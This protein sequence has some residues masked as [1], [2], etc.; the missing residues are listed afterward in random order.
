MDYIYAKRKRLITSR[1]SIRVLLFLLAFSCIGGSGNAQ[2]TNNYTNW[3]FG[4]G[5]GVTF[6]SGTV[7]ALTTGK[8]HS[9]EGCA[10]ISDANGQLL[11]YTDGQTI[12][13]RNHDVMPG[14]TGLGGSNS[15][16]QSALIVPY[17]NSTAQFYVFSVAA[18]ADQTGVQY[19]IV[20]MTLDDGR[21]GLEM[22]NKPV[23]APA[24][25][26]ITAI[27]HCNNL[28]HWIITHERGNNVFRV[29]LLNDNGLIPTATM[30]RVGSTHSSGKGYMKPSHDGRKL[31]VAVSGGEQGGFLE[32]F[33]FD[34]KTGAISKPVKLEI[35]ESR[36]AY[37]VEF[38]PDNKLL[39]LSTTSS[40][41]IYQFTVDGLAIQTA[42]SVK[43]QQGTSLGVGALQL[44]P[45]GK[46]YGA[47]PG[48]GYLLAI[49]QPNQVGAGCGLVSK[50]IY[51]GGRIAEAG[52]PF[53]LDEIPLLPPGLTI[54]LTKQAG[55][56]KYVLDSQPVNL[57]PAYLIY[58]W[59]VNGV[60][61]AGGNG[62][63]LQPAKSGTYTLKV[64]ETKCR[65]IQQFSNEMP[66][67]L[68]EVNPTVTATPDSCGTFRLA[69]HAN[70]GNIVWRGPGINPANSHLDSMIIAGVNGNRTYQVRV[71]DP[72]DSTCS[73]QKEV[74]FAFTVPPAFQ[75]NPSSRSSCG[76]SLLITATPTPDWNTF[77]WLLPDGS[78]VTGKS[79]TARQSG[80]YKLTAQSTAS[81]CRSETSVTVALNPIPVLQ[82]AFHQIDTCFANASIGYVDLD[83][84][85]VMNGRFTWTKEGSV[86][87][88][89]QRQEVREFGIFTV[90]VRTPAGCSA[91][92]SVRVVSTCPPLPPLMSIPDA[93]TP[94]GDGMN[95][96]LVIF[97]SGIDQL[98]LFI[99]NR[100]GEVIYSGMEVSP[101]PSGW[102]TW[103]GTYNDKPVEGGIY[104]YRLEMQSV[105]IPVPM[106]RRGI[107]QVIR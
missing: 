72:G 42:L 58:Q 28:N 25:E 55:C 57:D 23:V 37:G 41:T 93:F 17:Q 103:D 68:V 75:L 87:G 47:I 15:S 27:N 99:Y 95:E 21:G 69:A 107:I 53:V 3:Y 100:W 66:V 64:R 59:Y 67:T 61:V 86:I 74:S 14:A 50:A 8:L 56:N 89:S 71:S 45:D 82:L 76:D 96:T 43:S 2:S 97:A 6:G 39:Y 54:T 92:D 4:D 35:P 7:Q 48:E 30:Y 44:G 104:N 46:L 24:T 36:G 49:N 85:T 12:W 90:S 1:S 101:K 94:N 80:V 32:V 13:N 33:D 84:G 83:A 91:N 34:N 9:K 51:L 10:S 106:V 60:A 20:N 38:S 29:N 105:A 88:T 78:K 16:T 11:F 52:L 65:D 81:G 79:I 70:G 102:K 63:T 31:A 98:R 73:F 40:K 18:E 5:A 26:K 19:A 22:K 77:Q 62:P